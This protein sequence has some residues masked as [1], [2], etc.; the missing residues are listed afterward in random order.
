MYKQRTDGLTSATRSERTKVPMTGKVRREPGRG[1]TLLWLWRV[2]LALLI[3]ILSQS[4]EGIA[5]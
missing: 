2:L 5:K 3:L 4:Q 1:F